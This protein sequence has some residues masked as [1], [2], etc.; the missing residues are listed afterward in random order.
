MILYDLCLLPAH[1]CYVIIYIRKVESHVQISDYLHLGKF[2]M[3]QR[4]LFCRRCNFKMWVSDANS[5][6]GQACHYWSNQCFMEGYQSVCRPLCLLLK[7]G[8][9]STWLCG[10]PFLTA[11]AVPPFL[12]GKRSVR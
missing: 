3:V 10:M 7:R 9:R 2:P 1:F 6:L 11:T 5:L 12:P 8:G 4:T